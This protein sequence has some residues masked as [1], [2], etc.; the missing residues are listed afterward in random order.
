MSFIEGQ[1]H[2][3]SSVSAGLP[4]SKTGSA[5]SVAHSTSP[6]N[7]APPSPRPSL[8]STRMEGWVYV[9]LWHSWGFTPNWN[10]LP[11]DRA[12]VSS[13]VK[14]GRERYQYHLPL[15]Q[16]ANKRWGGRAPGKTWR[17]P[18]HGSPWIISILQDSALLQNLPDYFCSHSKWPSPV[19][20]K[21]SGKYIFGSPVKTWLVMFLINSCVP[22][23]F[24]LK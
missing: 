22:V 1:P 17:W 2:S 4:P 19:L 24:P 9:H 14:R 5:S 21:Y 11:T 12:S 18:R 16:N 8:Y 23:T 10:T 13:C 15:L 6:P 3:R 7:M 20:S